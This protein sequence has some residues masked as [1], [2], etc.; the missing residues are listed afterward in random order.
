[1]KIVLS[2]VET[3][4]K[5]AELML[6]AILQE[7]ER[8]SPG[9]EIYLPYTSVRQGLDYIHTPLKLFYWPVSKFLKKTCAHGIFSLL[10]LPAKYMQD[11]YAVPGADYFIDGSG[12]LF[13][14]QWK[15]TEEDVWKW[16]HLLKRMNN[17]G[18]KIIFLPQA[19][20]PLELPNTKEIIASLN[21]YSSVIMVRELV[22]YNYLKDSGLLDMK[23]VKM[24]SDFTSLVEG[25][26]PK[27]FSHLKNGVCV[28]P[29]MRMIDMGAVTFDN[30]ISL[31]SDI[32]KLAK[33]RD[34]IVY[35]LNH[36]GPVDE[37]LAYKCQKAMNGE[38]EVVTGINALEVKGL[39]STAYALITSRFHGAASALNCGVPC[40]ATSWSHKY[41]ELFN[42]YQMTDC[43]M[44]LDNR[45]KALEMVSDILNDNSN[46]AFRDILISQQS[47][48]RS[49]AEMM[50]KTIW[51]LNNK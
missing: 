39:I 28:I 41:K 15:A 47:K 50:W 35:L 27:Q 42:D 16:E 51:D 37:S 45:E 30:Y 10:H 11:V 4:N 25:V 29:N 18:T 31:L 19:F 2:G 20:G 33:S 38:I 26:F 14:D 8:K 22:S 36:E 24:F 21:K 3:N 23:K 5:G 44:P 34:L 7:I 17:N 32:I 49:E 43:I 6:Y 40:L 46:K 1:M 48:R 9:S 13:T 12:F